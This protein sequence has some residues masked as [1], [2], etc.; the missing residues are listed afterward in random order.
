MFEYETLKLIWWGFV[1]ILIIGFALMDGFDFGVGILLPFVAKTDMERRIVINSI[2]PTWE[3]NQTWFIAAGGALFAAWPLAYAAAFS[4]FYVALMLLLFSL[5]F[6]PVGFD[7]RSKVQDTR[8]RSAWDWALFIGGFVPPLIFGVAFGN[9]LLGVPFHYDETMRLEYMGGIL[10]LLNPFGLLAGLL[11]VAMLTMH[12][13]AFLRMKTEGLI[14][15]R[16]RTA[17][18][19][20]AAIAFLSFGCAGIWVAFGMDGYRIISM[21]DVNTAFMPTMKVAE[22]SLGAWLDNFGRMPILWGL[23]VAGLLAAIL[24]P[25]FACKNKDMTAFLSSGLCVAMVIL[26][27]G[28]AMFPFVMPSSLNPSSSLTAWDVVASH[29]SLGVMFWVVVIFLPV[30]IIYTSWIYR[31]LRGKVNEAHINA[32]EHSAY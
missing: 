29:K 20:A 24:S 22:R 4:G 12:G 6:R 28:V 11:S 25:L 13:A 3:G 18:L 21:P 10:G 8:W 30:I 15:E 23:P 14:R 17:L 31:V 19:V 16:A 1:G 7:Y 32:N 5:F 27:A 26:T 9:L 2:G